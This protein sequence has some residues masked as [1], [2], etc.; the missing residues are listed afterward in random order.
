MS[1]SINRVIL[2]VLDS[3]GI[4]ELPDAHLYNDKGSNTLG[5]IAKSYPDLKIPNLI[6]LGLGNIDMSNDLPKS[7]SP[8]SSF[9]KAIERSAGKDTTT[10]HWEISGIILDNAFPTFPSGFPTKFMNRFHDEIGTET[11]GNIV[12]SGTTI[13]ND[14]GDEHVKT[15]KPIVYTSADSVFQIAMHEDVIPIERQ[16]EIC[17]I[18]RDL[19]INEFEVGRVIARPFIGTSNQYSRTSRRKDYSVQPPDNILDAIIDHN[20]E[21]NSIGKIVDIFDGKGISS[22]KKTAN[23]LE[24]IQETISAIQNPSKGLIFT[25]LVDFDMLFGHRRNVEGYANCLMEFDKYIPEILDA[26]QEDDLLIIT[27]DHGN[28][29]TAPGTDHTREYIPILNIGTQIKNGYDIGVRESFAD[30]AATIAEALGI[31]FA[32]EGRSYYSSIN[33]N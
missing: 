9:G 27:A 8:S 21:V 4:G 13:I 33:S 1:K 5:N 26:L 2:I 29:P 28:D 25:N 14:L 23:N 3:V 11:I 18:A 20:L 7:D 17:Q 24:G 12:A 6:S 31:D 30:I 15:A 10:G 19:L 22:Y 16:Y 32:T